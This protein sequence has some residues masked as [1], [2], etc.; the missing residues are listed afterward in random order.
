MS[1][2]ERNLAASGAARLDRDLQVRLAAF[3]WLARQAELH[4]DVLTWPTL[5][6]GFAFHGT[7]VP[8]VSMQGIFKPAICEIPLSIRTSFSGPYDD[9]FLADDLLEYRYRGTDPNHRD[10][11]G[12]RRAMEERRPLIHLYGLVKGRYFVI[13]PVY[14][15]HDDPKALTFTIQADA[16]EAALTDTAPEPAAARR[17]YVTSTVRRRLHQRSFRER[18]LAAYRSQCSMCRLKHPELLDAAH[19]VPDSDPRGTPEVPNGLSLCK[20]HHAAFDRHIIGV[21]ADYGIVVRE[22]I[23][24]EIDGPMLQHGLKELHGGKL[25][26]PRNQPL[27]PDRELLGLRFEAFRRAG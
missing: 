6:R 2:A 23:L 9:S 21:S 4:G 22:D 7:K 18:V 16:S 8:L 13:W 14:V 15:V 10:N 27:R 20:I 25:V 19:I 26:V 1:A 24:E 11:R 5:I 12:L 3:D 17:A